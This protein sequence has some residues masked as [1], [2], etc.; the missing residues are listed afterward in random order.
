MKK[1]IG[2]YR[3]CDIVTMISCGTA[4]SG[5]ILAINSRIE[6]S[7]ICL[8]LS[9]ICDV[10]DGVLA[11]KRK[12]SIQQIRYG[13][14]LDS[15]SDIVAFGVLPV[16][17]TICNGMNN[18]VYYPIY[19]FY[20]LC[21]LIRLAYFNMLIHEDDTDKK[22]FLGL[23]ITSIAII[24]PIFY[25]ICKFAYKYSSYILG[26]MLVVIGLLYVLKIKV[27]K[28]S[29]ELRIVL[30]ILGITVSILILITKCI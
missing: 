22:C 13:E 18:I 29:I 8:I 17:I 30:A 9:G 27:K 16:I 4:I 25:I 24:Y 7:I 20:V 6:L 3:L 10:F 14:Q 2:I 26:L 5:I 23:P 21:G 1:F 15:L 19:I 28:P 11:R 12:N